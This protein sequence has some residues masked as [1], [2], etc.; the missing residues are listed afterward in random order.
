M[1][2]V[3]GSEEVTLT[4]AEHGCPTPWSKGRGKHERR[5]E[6]ID[7][8]DESELE[9]RPFGDNRRYLQDAGGPDVIPVIQNDFRGEVDLNETVEEK[10]KKRPDNR[11]AGRSP[12]TAGPPMEPATHTHKKQKSPCAPPCLCRSNVA[13]PE[14]LAVVRTSKVGGSVPCM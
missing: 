1:A 2:Q 9:G 10:W 3:V 8:P 5:A 11:I 6:S 12:D 13:C 14:P 4:E 7:A